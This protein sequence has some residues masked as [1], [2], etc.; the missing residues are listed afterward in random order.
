MRCCTASRGCIF[1]PVA[2]IASMS[3]LLA[4][5]SRT[6]SGEEEEAVAGLQR[7]PLYVVL[8]FADRPERRVCCEAYGLDTSVA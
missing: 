8:V 6:P 2:T 4:L 3:T 7:Q 1:A 5:R